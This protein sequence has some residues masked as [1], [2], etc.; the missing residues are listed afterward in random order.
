MNRKSQARASSQPP[1]PVSP[2]RATTHTAEQDSMADNAAVNRCW[3]TSPAAGSVTGAVAGGGAS[4]FLLDGGETSA[5]VR[6]SAPAGPHALL[7]I[8]RI[9]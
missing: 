2:L 6:V 4:G 1:P 3:A 7:S 5:I 9:R 8:A